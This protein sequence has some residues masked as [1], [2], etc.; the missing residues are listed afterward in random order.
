MCVIRCFTHRPPANGES[1]ASIAFGLRK[2]HSA[3]KPLP[4]LAIRGDAT[5]YVQNWTKK[6]IFG[7][8]DQKTNFDAG[9]I[10]QKPVLSLKGIFF[11]LNDQF[12]G[13]TLI[14]AFNE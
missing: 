5:F 10:P 13:D 12:E 4:Q 14:A 3:G 11:I 9:M 2:G 7:N 8:K 1:D 6:V